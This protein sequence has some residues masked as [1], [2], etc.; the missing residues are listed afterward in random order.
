MK[1]LITTLIILILISNIAFADILEP[2]VANESEY[3]EVVFLS[4]Q[5]VELSG[6][7]KITESGT[8]AVK[9]SPMTIT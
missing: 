3:K 8:G 5:P 1:R 6:K 2:G 9:K 7:V 4:G